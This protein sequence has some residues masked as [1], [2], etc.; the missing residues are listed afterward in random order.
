M[1]PGAVSST[2]KHRE[3][4]EPL[5]APAR[6]CSVLQHARVAEAHCS[7]PFFQLIKCEVCWQDINM[8]SIGSCRSKPQIFSLCRR[9]FPNL[10][11]FLLLVSESSRSKGLQVMLT[12]NQLTVLAHFHAFRRERTPGR[13]QK[14]TLRRIQCSSGWLKAG[15]SHNS[16]PKTTPHLHY[17][18]PCLCPLIP[19]LPTFC[20]SLMSHTRFYL[21]P[22]HLKQP[23][24]ISVQSGSS[25][26][27]H[28]I[29]SLYLCTQTSLGLQTVQWRES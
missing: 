2:H 6:S 7:T 14:Q 24:K 28:P 8:P 18:F 27:F 10:N 19:L 9:W 13:R 11:P 26:P 20:P 16:V 5:L 3:E 15:P 4:T 1:S 25:L 12:S 22:Q 17:I 23:T 29:F 21:F